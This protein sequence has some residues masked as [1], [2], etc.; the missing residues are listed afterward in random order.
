MIK[1]MTAITL[2]TRKA[3]ARAFSIAI[4]TN[5]LR[6][7]PLFFSHQNPSLEFNNHC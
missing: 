6:H 5:R 4:Y 1:V 7:K 3:L 2:K